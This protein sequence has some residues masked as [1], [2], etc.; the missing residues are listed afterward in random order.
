MLRAERLLRCHVVHGAHHG[1][2]AGQICLGRHIR[3]LDPRQTHVQN[4]HRS[5]GVDQQ[6]SGLDIA[7]NDPLRMSELQAT[8]HLDDAVNRLADRQRPVL[9]DDGSQ[10][11]AG[12]VFHH[13]ERCPVGLARIEGS[14]DVGVR[15]PCRRFDFTLKPLLQFLCLG[16]SGRQHL[17]R[18]QPFHHPVL[19]LQHHPHPAL[20]K[21]VQNEVAADHQRLSLSGINHL[22]LVGAD[23]LLPDQPPG[24]LFA[25]SRLFCCGQLFEKSAQILTGQ[26]AAVRKLLRELFEGHRHSGGFPQGDE[27]IR[28]VMR[29]HSRR[30]KTSGQ[31]TTGQELC[32]RIWP[33]ICRGATFDGSRGFQPTVL[34]HPYDFSS[35]SD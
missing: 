22:S 35:R 29:Q 34:E 1:P 23:F 30:A 6:I 17:D 26:H 18:H 33:C 32:Q 13:Q 19:S 21:H 27:T 24:Q 15:Q 31:L 7:V 14:H 8:R 2:A 10:V 25:V 16:D 9:L 11:I 5:P 4:L 3:G 12:D 28:R 20:A